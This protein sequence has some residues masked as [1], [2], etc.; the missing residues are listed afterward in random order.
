MT[1]SLAILVLIAACGGSSKHPTTSMAET[2]EAKGPTDRIL[3]LLPDGAQVIVEL[4]LARLR[5][6]P[7]VGAL[8]TSA[9]LG[10]AGDRL[11]AEVAAE[12]LATADALVLA[13]YGVG[14]GKAATVIVLATKNAV[15]NGVPLGEGLV[16]LGPSDWTG[17]LEA[18]A[19]I[20]GVTNGDAPKI[21]PPKDMMEVRDHAIPPK[22]PGSSFRLTARLPF[23]A[24]VELARE[25]N[26]DTVPSELSIW[27]DFVD[28]FAIIIDADAGDGG[29]ASKDDV[30]R[31]DKAT[32]RMLI[33]LTS[34]PAVKLLGLVPSIENA[35]ITAQGAWL[36]TIVVVGPDRLSRVVERAKTMMPKAPS[37]EK[38]DAEPAKDSPKPVETPPAAPPT[39]APNLEL[40]RNTPPKAP[41]PQPA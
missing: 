38:P 9:I 23:D 18:R 16:A 32:R 31:L 13:A 3:A 2:F 27:A 36:R 12:P 14:T 33:G 6:N 5:A 1:R 8:V 40:P 37:T 28:D 20:A 41:A 19:A 22:A 34:E 26:L 30:K 15:P 11:P 24:R 4:D 39:K 25:L 35:R 7:V 29:K 21:M 10:G 17:Q